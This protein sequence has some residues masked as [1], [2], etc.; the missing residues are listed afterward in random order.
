MSY[1]TENDAISGLENY[2]NNP[3]LFLDSIPL[4]KYGKSNE[5]GIQWRSKTKK[6]ILKVRDYD[7]KKI[8]ITFDTLEHAKL[9]KMEYLNNKQLFLNKFSNRRTKLHIIS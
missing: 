5:R 1:K 6:W 3:D 8:S 4:S 2:K 7:K 9:A